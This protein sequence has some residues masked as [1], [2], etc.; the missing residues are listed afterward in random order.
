MAGLM[1]G[2]KPDIDVS[3]LKCR[4]ARI[5]GLGDGQTAS[6]FVNATAGCAGRVKFYQVRYYRC[7]LS[8]FFTSS[9]KV[10]A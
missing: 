3:E 10:R 9:G 1:L 2:R 8:A 4:A 5:T 7:A 6:A